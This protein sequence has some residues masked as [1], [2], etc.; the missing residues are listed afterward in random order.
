MKSISINVTPNA[1]ENLGVASVSPFEQS[2]FTPRL[3]LSQGTI[4]KLSPYVTTEGTQHQDSAKASQKQLQ[5]A[6]AEQRQDSAKTSQKQLQDALTEQRQDSAKA[7]QKQL[8]DALAEQ[9]QDSAKTSQKQLQ[10]ALAEQ[11]LTDCLEHLEDLN[12]LGEEAQLFCLNLAQHLQ[13]GCG[14]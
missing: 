2:P 6:L 5:D 12:F 4:E 13:W 7:S 9:R 3:N 14:V 11:R 10:D 1:G 8:Q